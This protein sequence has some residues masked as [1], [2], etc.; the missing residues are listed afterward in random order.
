VAAVVE[1]LCLLFLIAPLV[2]VLVRVAREAVRPGE[3]RSPALRS[4]AR[5]GGALLIAGA[6]ATAWH[7]PALLKS[8]L[9]GWPGGAGLSVAAV[10]RPARAV[11][12]RQ[13]GLPF[14][15]LAVYGLLVL[16]RAVN[17]RD[18]TTVYAWLAGLYVL[19][20]F[21]PPGR[22]WD[23]LG[24]LVP[25]ASASAV[26]LGALTK[27][28][29]TAVAVVA[30]F[31]LVQ[32]A[33]LTLPE[34]MVARPLGGFRWAGDYDFA[35]PPSRDDWSVE[36]ALRAI[37]AEKDKATVGLLC[38]HP[39]INAQTFGCVARR[40]GLSLRLVD[41]REQL[42]DFRENLGSYDLVVDKP[43]WRPPVGAGAFRWEEAR[44]HFD[45][46]RAG[47]RGIRSF[48]LP[49]GSSMIL[50]RNLLPREGGLAGPPTRPRRPAANRTAMIGNPPAYPS[51]HC[52]RWDP[53]DVA[54]AIPHP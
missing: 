47:F 39:V 26:G 48:N 21:F 37:A 29:R 18:A 7:A 14:F 33:A 42:E 53:G 31:A 6:I 35:R 40:L 11:V 15:A 1:P 16:P 3:Q 28:R 2:H 24:L 50:Y 25:L 19:L 46:N 13:I 23:A 45:E 41:C 54:G 32:F 12:V 38:D 5:A 36:E 52:E 20:V 10:L 51:P 49:D 17:R 34:P 4:L 27:F 43:G 22:G 30:A 9:S 44:R 8:G